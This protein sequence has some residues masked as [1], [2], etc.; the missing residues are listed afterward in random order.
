MTV[1]LIP[2]LPCL[3]PSNGLPLHLEIKFKLYHLAPCFSRS[4][5]PPPKKNSPLGSQD[6]EILSVPGMHKAPSCRVLAPA[7]QFYH[8]LLITGS[9]AQISAQMP[10]PPGSP[11]TYV[12]YFNSLLS[13]ITLIKLSRFIFFVAITTDYIILLPNI[14]SSL[15]PAW[16]TAKPPVPRAAH[17]PS[18]WQVQDN[19]LL[20]E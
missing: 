14:T 2:S 15:R 6:R 12:L 16:F 19:H 20:N 10:A 5:P 8:N 3:K 7:A 17:V 11:L 4:A 1:N 13:P 9:L 18:T